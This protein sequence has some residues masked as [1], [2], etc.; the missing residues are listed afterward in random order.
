MKRH[1]VFFIVR[2]S[3]VF[4]KNGKKSR[5]FAIKAPITTIFSSL[6]PIFLTDHVAE[7]VLVALD[8]TRGY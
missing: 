6:K 8:L 1:K 2:G 4:V 7:Y 5:V 3:Q